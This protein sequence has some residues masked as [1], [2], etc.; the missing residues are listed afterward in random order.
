MTASTAT[1]YRFLKIEHRGPVTVLFVHRPDVLNALNHDTLA[2]IDDAV[3]RFVE[4]PAQGGTKRRSGSEL[5]EALE[6]LGARMGVSTGWEGTTISVSCLAERLA[7]AIGIL[8]E[9]V[10]EP[11][12]PE[13]EVVRARDQQ[14]AQIRQRAM[15]PSSLAADQA[16]RRIFA[17][18]VP[19]ARPLAGSVASAGRS[20]LN[21]GG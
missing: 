1:A 4:D 3:R 17:A 13:D 9:T 14:L 7:E 12:F 5:A 15:D 8:A 10:L 11:E 6:R 2:E 20:S 19:Y 21:G 18:D 16:S